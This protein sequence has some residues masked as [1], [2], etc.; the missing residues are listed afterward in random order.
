MTLDDDYKEK[1]DCRLRKKVPWTGAGVIVACF[2]VVAFLVYNAYSGEQKRQSEGIAENSAQVQE[3]KTNV[4]VMEVEFGHV[5]DKLQDL[6]NAQEAQFREVIEK[7]D[8][9]NQR[10]DTRR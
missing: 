8:R 3:L 10:G 9:L 5:R 2:T 4:K 7:L 6:K 1:V